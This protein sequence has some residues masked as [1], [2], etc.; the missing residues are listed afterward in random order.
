MNSSD[1][2][3]TNHSMAASL[4]AGENAIDP[5]CTQ[6]PRIQ[7]IC[8][9]LAQTYPPVSSFLDH[10]TPFSLLVAVMLSAQSTDLMVNKVTPVLRQWADTPEKMLAKGHDWLCEHVQ[11]LGLYRR[12][13]EHILA[14][15]QRLVDTYKGQVPDQMQDLLTLPGVGRKTANVVLNVL[16]NQATIPV[17]THIARLSGRLGLS[18]SPN[19]ER[20]EQDLHRVIPQAYVRHIHALLILHGRTI[21]KAR[22]PLCPIC[23]LR[24]LC[25]SAELGSQA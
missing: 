12:K 3:Q 24:L 16:F 10:T 19:P 17:D 21:C 5:T 14:T 15:A 6:R 23:P 13:A 18:G 22:R 8:A 1:Y 7:Q 20:I 25:P 9:L 2:D 11:R 4:V